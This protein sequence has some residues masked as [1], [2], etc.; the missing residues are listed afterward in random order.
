MEV[1]ERLGEL[2]REAGFTGERHSALAGLPGGVPPP[3]VLQTANR[4]EDARLAILLKLFHNDETVAREAAEQALRPLTIEDLEEAGLMETDAAGVH[5][6]MKVSVIDDLMVAGDAGE[7]RPADFVVDLSAAAVS[8]AGLTV[9]REIES[10]LDLGTG[11][12][13]H[14]LL[15]AQHA[16]RVVGVDINPHAL[17][18]ARVGQRLNRI[19]NVSWLEGDWFE[20]VRGQRF[21]LVVAAPPVVISPD[22]AL[23]W[24]DSPIGG[25][26]LSRQ[27]VR[28]SADHLAEGGF[29]TLFCHWTH[30]AEGWED[31]PREWVAGLGCDALILNFR[32]RQP[33]SQALEG[34]TL[35]PG[36]EREAFAD[37]VKRWM[38]HYGRAGIEQIAGGVVVLRRSSGPNWTRA[39]YLDHGTRRAGGDQLE[40]IF[41]GTDFLTSHSG[42]EQLRELMSSAWQLVEGHRLDQALT[43]ENGAYEPGDAVMSQT[44]GIG[45]FARVDPRVVPVVIA[46]DGQRP[47]AE[48]LTATPIPEGLDR[49]GFHSLCL[50]TIKDLI[51]RGYLHRDATPRGAPE[52]AVTAGAV[53]R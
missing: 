3:E 4:P 11:S 6:R 8:V 38:E 5:A 14:A 46:C 36:T 16:N 33:L 49:S 48:A 26:A 24:R 7:N 25:E 32:S 29:A 42:A 53:G 43:Y 23:L 34:V 44:P 37:G 30:G 40:R 2:L 17:S 31:P 41:A 15:A 21:D 19:D 20:P 50:A 52:A 47:L 51:A 28:E 9:R 39:F 27:I 22:N 10:A 35:A 13:V 45:L 18:V 1:V 12:G